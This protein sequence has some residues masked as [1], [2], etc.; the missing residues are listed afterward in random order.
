MPSNT[1]KL[2]I[3][4]AREYWAMQPLFL[5][6]ETTGTDPLAEIVEIAVVDIQD[7]VLFESLVK[8]VRKIPLEA[9][10]VHHITE[11]MVMNAPTWPEV[12]PQ[13]EAVAARRFVGIY[14]A[15]FDLRMI[16]QSFLARGLPVKEPPF[17][18]FCLMK[19]YAEFI[20]SPRWVTLEQA[21]L[22]SNI[23][24]PNAHRAR[25]DAIVTRALLQYMA[26][27]GTRAW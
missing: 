24:M 27:A 18:S 14:N 23:A 20:E 4:K 6:T 25:A 15:D 16:R 3:Q 5:D 17:R 2:A 7:N 1:R 8:P 13:F 22:R 21:R 19:L 11:E 26:N 9:L 12:W 10:R